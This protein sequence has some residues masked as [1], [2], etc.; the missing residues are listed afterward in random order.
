MV[1]SAHNP[2]AK[3]SLMA[4]LN[5]LVQGC[6]LHVSWDRLFK[7]FIFI[8]RIIA[9]QWS[10][11]L[12]V[13]Q[14]ESA[15]KSSPSC[16][17]LPPPILSCP[18]RVSQSTGLSSLHQS[19]HFPLAVYFP[20]GSGYVSALLSQLV[21]WDSPM[22]TPE[23]GR[24]EEWKQY[25]VHQGGLFLLQ[26]WERSPFHFIEARRPGIKESKADIHFLALTQYI[27][28]HLS[29]SA[30]AHTHTETGTQ[31]TKQQTAAVTARRK[32]KVYGLM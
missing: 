25:A 31:D 27:H 9:L 28:T 3:A 20:Y 17:S 12:C 16:S 6:M 5:M 18:C 11:G 32:E 15:V 10:V 30:R 29:T 24:G 14:H 4:K 26:S 13:R 23:T 1:T 21:S 19:A 2:R 22:V 8:W 7:L